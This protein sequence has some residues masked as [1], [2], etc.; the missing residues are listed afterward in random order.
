MDIA[1]FNA[2]WLK[3]WSDKDV[4]RL[5]GFY[6]EDAT[7]FDPQVP[8]GLK[9][10]GPLREY[11]KTLFSSTPATT[12]TPEEVWAI[13]GGFCGRWYADIGDD[14]VDAR[15]RGF[16]QVILRDGLIAHNEVYVHQL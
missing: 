13:E 10:R 8:N 3:A 15:L 1:N 9:G 12:Y 7:Y 4:E 16:D 5:V 2:D 14:K 6:A 11:L